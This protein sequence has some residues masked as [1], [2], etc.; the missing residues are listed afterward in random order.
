MCFVFHRTVIFGALVSEVARI[1]RVKSFVEFKHGKSLC[2]FSPRKLEEMA[3]VKKG[4]TSTSI[5]EV[6][7][8][9]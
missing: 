5:E 4:Q 6:S 2:N 7:E 1:L 8:N 9:T 3:K